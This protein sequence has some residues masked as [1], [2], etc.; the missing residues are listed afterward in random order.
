MAMREIKFRGKSTDTGQWRI[1]DLNILPDGR[2]LI[3]QPYFDE[4]KNAMRVNATPVEPESVGQYTGFKDAYD[5]EIYEGD[6]IIFDKDGDVDDPCYR[7]YWLDGG[8][9]I[10]EAET[11]EHYDWLVEK[12]SK[13]C[14]VI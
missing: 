3:L 5:K 1:G 13:T 12:N 7:V 6:L 11:S 14:Y 8:W 2:V 10:A 4:S 9:A